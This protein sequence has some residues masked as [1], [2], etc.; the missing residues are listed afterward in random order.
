MPCLAPS[1]NF[2]LALNPVVPN[3]CGS[4]RYDHK[5]RFLIHDRDSIF[6]TD[7]D[8]SLAR[9]GLKV[10]PTPL[11]SPQANSLCERLIGTLRR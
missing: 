10:I 6:S 8:A 2:I 9:L 4:H 7:L 5:Y 11:R 3:F 1:D